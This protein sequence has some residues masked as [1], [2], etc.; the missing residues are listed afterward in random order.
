MTA[1][2]STAL[3][4]LTAA[5]HQTAGALPFVER[6]AALALAGGAAYL[7]DDPAAPLTSVVPKGPWRRRAPVVA[8][9]GT[10]LAGGWLGILLL[11]TWRDARPPVAETSAQLVVMGLLAIAAAAL[12]FRLGDPEPG[13]IVA[14]L[15]VVLGLA[16][17]IVE[18][19]VDTPIFLTD[20]APTAGRVAGWSAAGA[21]AVMVIVIGGRDGAGEPKRVMRPRAGRV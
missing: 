5:F 3:V 16:V 13:T 19:V 17:T 8:A 6:V 4:L 9:G 21:V 18:S 11:L 12:L 10:L 1:L 14:P 15:V 20:A 7:L 2:V